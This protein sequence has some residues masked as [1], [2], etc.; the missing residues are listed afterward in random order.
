MV[1]GTHQG[2]DLSVCILKSCRSSCAFLKD[3]L[4][5]NFG[6]VFCHTPAVSRR[7]Y[8]AALKRSTLYSAR[9]LGA[10]RYP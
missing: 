4:I 8:N 6:L 2:G 5:S 7:L 10:E 9:S 1:E 3:D